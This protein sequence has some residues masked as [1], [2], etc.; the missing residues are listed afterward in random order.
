M[1]QRLLLA[2]VM[3]LAA[4]PLPS[5]VF[6]ANGHYVAGA[7]GIRG[8]SVPP[9]GL[10]YRAYLVHYDIE[11]LRDGR[12]DKVPGHNTGK[13]TALTNRVIWI[14]DKKFLGADYGM[15]AIIPVQHTSL[16]FK[17]SGVDDSD[18]GL[19]DIFIGPM[20]LGW[21]GQQWDATFGAGYWFD[22]GDYDDQAAAS[23]GKGFG[24]TMLTLGGTWH[25]DAAKTWSFSALSRY[26]IK[27][28]QDDTGITPGDSWLVE[29]GL[30]HHLSNGLALGLVG[31]DAW[32]LESDEDV[33]AGLPDDKV[34]QHAVGV[35][36]DYSW[37]ELELGL[38]G[39]YYNEYDNEARP[40]GDLFRFVLTKGF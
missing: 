19:G 9:T 26:E 28:E 40:E 39:A 20:I 6:A 15:E 7:E 18:S 29:W 5:S 24:T 2:L 16:D 3:A 23:N 12:G 11:R 17:G 13:I 8:A 36:V 25:F 10:Y 33:P 1:K 35:E 21:H 4:V 31:Y 30:S 14:T 22:T 37:P 38:N 32:Q 27:G 34:E